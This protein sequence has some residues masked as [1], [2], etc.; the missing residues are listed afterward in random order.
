[1]WQYRE[2]WTIA[3]SWYFL[4]N[5]ERT[6]SCWL[7]ELRL[8]SFDNSLLN[9]NLSQLVIPSPLDAL[10]LSASSSGCLGSYFRRRGRTTL[11]CA[12]IYTSTCVNTFVFTRI[13]LGM[14]HHISLCAAWVEPNLAVTFPQ[15]S[16][17][18]L[19]ISPSDWDFLSSTRNS[20][21][22]WLMTKFR[23]NERFVLLRVIVV[24]ESRRCVVCRIDRVSDRLCMKAYIS[25][26]MSAKKYFVYVIERPIDSY[27]LTKIRIPLS[28][29]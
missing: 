15:Y 27:Y 24:S 11:G 13:L 16:L 10:H 3:F 14:P 1:M 21:K 2:L 26:V 12:P 22:T 17:I 19:R 9:S 8:N 4:T 18:L 25:P 29:K 7:Y 5:K 6:C 23:T 28:S 20:T